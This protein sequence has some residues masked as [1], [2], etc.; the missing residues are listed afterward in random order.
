M[1]ISLFKKLFAVLFLTTLMV[2]V[3]M[4][5][6]IQWG[7]DRGFL[8]YINIEEQEEIMRLA[9]K[10]EDYYEV[11]Q[12]WDDLARNPDKIMRMHM[13]ILP[14]GKMKHRLEDL[15]EKSHHFIKDP[16]SSSDE[17]EDRR[18]YPIQRTVIL[19]GA[20]RI[21]FG[22][23]LQAMLPHMNPLMYHDERVGSIGVYLP[24]KLSESNQL[25][26]SEKQTTFIFM[27]FLISVV[28]A[29]GISMFLA[30]S[31]A[32]PIRRLSVLN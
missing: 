18:R 15:T 10:L 29:I 4:T 9:D 30:Y 8:E 32:R 31:L 22:E 24:Q 1:N 19:D 3:F 17:K 28:I 27:A 7:F 26:F 13:E 6:V 21:I 20:G 11:H 12:S 23:R 2:A 25:T 16:R 5:F 14:P